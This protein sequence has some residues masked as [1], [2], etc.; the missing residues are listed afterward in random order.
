MKPIWMKAPFLA[1]VFRLLM[2]IFV[3][4]FL[5]CSDRMVLLE[6]KITSLEDNVKKN[7]EIEAYIKQI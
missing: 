4:T 1:Y 6:N 2:V 3:I 5:P 7:Q